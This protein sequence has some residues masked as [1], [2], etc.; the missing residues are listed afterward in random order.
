[1]GKIRVSVSSKLR[2]RLAAA[3]LTV[4]MAAAMAASSLTNAAAEAVQDITALYPELYA[5]KEATA[6]A[7]REPEKVV[8]LTFDDGPSAVTETIL[9]IL[10]E[11][12][13]KATFFVIG[14]AGEETDARLRR[15]AQEGHAIGVH[16]Y[17]HRYSQ[18]YSSVEGW[19][20]DF[21]REREW[22]YSVTGQRPDFF[23][24]PGGST[25]SSCDG[26]VR[27]DIQREMERRGF[28][29]FDWNSKG[30]DDTGGYVA[31]ETIARR[32]LKYARDRDRVIVL[33]HDSSVRR[34]TAEALPILIDEFRRQG[35]AFAA[36]SEDVEPMHLC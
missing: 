2:V 3:G 18:I 1:M 17:C 29:W 4:L 24:F 14:P 32:I 10:K 13:I 36:L 5:S 6:D 35:Y 15:I 30:G 9:D 16:S 12:G 11:N 34:T 20:A 26:R 19:L 22:I 21:E 23:R 25:N 8:Y 33:C 31:A 28:V 27:E 7:E